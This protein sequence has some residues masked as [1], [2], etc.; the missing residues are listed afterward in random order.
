MLTMATICKFNKFGFCRYGKNCNFVHIEDK[1]EKESCDVKVCAFRHPKNCRYIEKHQ[2][3]KFDIFCV[4][5]HGCES[6]DVSQTSKKEIIDRINDLEQIIQKQNAKID[7]LI[8]KLKK[9]ECITNNP[10]TSEIL[11]LEAPFKEASTDIN[12]DDVLIRKDNQFKCDKCDFKTDKNRGLSIHKSKKH[13]IDN[14]TYSEYFIDDTTTECNKMYKN[15][16]KVGEKQIMHLHSKECW[17][18]AHPCKIY[19]E[20]DHKGHP[21]IDKDGVVHVLLNNYISHSIIDWDQL[22][23][24]MVGF[25]LERLWLINNVIGL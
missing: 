9:Y 12:L 14:P 5:E 13:R 17:E 22:Y 23:I 24:V 3:C 20:R 8:E 16:Q 18:S 10:D 11:E 15:S 19:F 4:F 1:C 25:D 7:I 21:S 6:D 2:K